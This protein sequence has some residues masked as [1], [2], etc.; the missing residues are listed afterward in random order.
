MEVVHGAAVACRRL[1][2]LTIVG[3]ILSSHWHES[4][5][6]LLVNL[7][8]NERWPTTVQCD[9]VVE[10]MLVDG[11]VFGLLGCGHFIFRFETYHVLHDWFVVYGTRMHSHG[12]IFRLDIGEPA[13][14]PF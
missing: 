3:F 9:E 6:D 12:F 13:L 11:V 14:H 5:F 10:Q 8:L 1:A 4:A 7:I 2:F